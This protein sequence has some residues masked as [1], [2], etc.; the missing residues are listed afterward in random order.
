LDTFHG[1]S[2]KNGGKDMTALQK[3]M[4]IIN[5]LKIPIEDPKNSFKTRFILQKTAYISK[6]IGIDL[7]YSFNLY[8][9]GPYC[10]ALAL[11]YYNA[12][13]ENTETLDAGEEAKVQKLKEY[14][15]DHPLFRIHSDIML[16]ACATLLYIKDHSPI[17][18]LDMQLIQLTKGQKP[19]IPEKMILLVLNI[20]KQINFQPED[21]TP[22]LKDEIRLWDSVND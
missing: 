16:E 22:D 18:L 2:D 11:E 7:P 3:L 17:D 8:I 9:H 12:K 19:H 15:I 20:I 6:S 5:Q 14:L 10:P 4:G 21:I 13:P 1:E